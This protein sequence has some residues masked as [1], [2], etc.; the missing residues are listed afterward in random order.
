MSIRVTLK[1]SCGIEIAIVKKVKLYKHNFGAK[2]ASSQVFSCCYNLSKV[3]FCISL[4][5]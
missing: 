3:H 4:Q 5:R 2:K 1:F